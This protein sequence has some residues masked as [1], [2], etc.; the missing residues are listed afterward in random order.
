MKTLEDAREL[1]K[2]MVSIGTNMGRTVV[3]FITDMGQPLGFTVGN[4]LEVVEALDTLL[5]NG[6]E[7][8]TDLC[9][10]I[11][12]YMVWSA[13]VTDTLEEA[14]SLLKEQIANGKAHDKQLQFIAA[15]GGHLPELK[16]FIHVKEQ[17]KV[18]A[19]ESGYVKNINALTIG[20]SAMKL[21][22]GRATKEDSIDPDVGIVLNKKVGDQ[23]EKGETLATLYNNLPD[24]SEIQSEV[25]NAFTI[26]KEAVEKAPLIFEIIT[27]KD[28]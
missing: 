27:E 17:I 7:D 24:T 4:R 8:L 9:I 21:G 18:V 23:V 15:Q 10:E 25:L 22:A 16:D 1:S 6:P 28:L 13:K 19:L 2:I 5:G 20:I 14:K 11:G 3:A 12:S 26:T